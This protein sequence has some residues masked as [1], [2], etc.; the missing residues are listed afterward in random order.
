M[1][2]KIDSFNIFYTFFEYIIAL[3]LII[4]CRSMWVASSL[5]TT[6]PNKLILILCCSIVINIL[7]RKRISKNIINSFLIIVCLI[8]Y[9]LIYMLIT[10]AISGTLVRFTIAI[11]FFLLYFYSNPLKNSVSLLLRFDNLMIIIGGISIFLWLLLDVLHVIPFSGSVVSVW[12]GE[13]MNVPD[14]HSIFY[15]P[16]YA[17][18]MGLRLLRNTSIF[19]EA[20]MYSLL[21]SFALMIELLIKNTTVNKIRVAI[22]VIAIFTTFSFTGYALVLIIL[23]Y[24]YLKNNKNDSIA[25]AFR[26]VGV[27]ILLVIVALLIKN[28]FNS[29]AND[30]SG[31]ARLDDFVVGF[32]VWKS[33][34]I[35]GVGVD[36]DNAIKSSMG[37]WRSFNTGLSNSI[38]QLLAQGGL[39]LTLVYF[40]PFIK[41][42]CISIKN[43]NKN[44]MLFILLT[45]Y[46]FIFTLFTYQLI[47]ALL[48]V[49]IFTISYSKIGEKNAKI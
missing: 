42:I 21:L 41:G 19:V 12:T 26:V 2:I 24:I 8:S 13:P 9:I 17:N 48:L 40:V 3:I 1:K 27:P 11:S 16:Q 43:K 18:F 20:P 37:A 29:K 33:A 5:E 36:N 35:F 28:M 47:L 34:P 46:L 10:H 4:D 49:Y 30:G 45:L 22:L 32:N 14:F 38:T 25:K 23:L 6:L 7:L 44:E 39:Y 15:A 31:H